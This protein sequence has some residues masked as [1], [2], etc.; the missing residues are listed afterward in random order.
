MQASTLL[1][2]AESVSEKVTELAQDVSDVALRLAAKTPWV[3]AP[4]SKRRVPMW[5]V[6]VLV[7]G[8]LAALGWWFAKRSNSTAYVGDDRVEQARDIR[9][10]YAPTGT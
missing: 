1:D 4:R 5:I 7:L 8:A 2:T 10:R 6:P 3:E 9:G